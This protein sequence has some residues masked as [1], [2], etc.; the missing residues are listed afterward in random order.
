MAIPTFREVEEQVGAILVGQGGLATILV[1]LDPLA[2]I[3][4]SFGGSRLQG[5]SAAD[6]SADG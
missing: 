6:R 5:P 2:R 3:E 4:R 1:D